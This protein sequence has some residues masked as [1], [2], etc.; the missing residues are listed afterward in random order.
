MWLRLA[1]CTVSSLEYV[2]T[3]TCGVQLTRIIRPAGASADYN[4]SVH[5]C[6]LGL[7]MHKEDNLLP[8]YALK[9][10]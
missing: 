8:K 1:C 6:R 7:S 10:G 9:L 4:M 2:N 3:L 5:T